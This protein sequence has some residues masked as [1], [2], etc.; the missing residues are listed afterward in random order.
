MQFIKSSQIGKIKPARPE[1]RT[2]F[3]R[4]AASAIDVVTLFRHALFHDIKGTLFNYATNV[5]MTMMALILMRHMHTGAYQLFY[6]FVTGVLNP[7]I[8]I[9]L[10]SFTIVLVGAEFIFVGLTF[11]PKGYVPNLMVKLVTS[12]RDSIVVLSGASLSLAALMFG[13]DPVGRWEAC[14]TAVVYFASAYLVA[15]LLLA[16]FWLDSRRLTDRIALVGAGAGLLLLVWFWPDLFS[17]ELIKLD[18]VIG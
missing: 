3:H 1:R 10:A 15:F 12:I 8:L 6:N 4:T 18:K 7:S 17:P 2:L 5:V 13:G 14:A 11:Y 9:I 16:P